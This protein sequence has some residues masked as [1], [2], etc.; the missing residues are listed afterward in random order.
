MKLSD[1][2]HLKQQ[3]I[4][5]ILQDFSLGKLK[6]SPF[7]V[8]IWSFKRYEMEYQ[9]EYYYELEAEQFTFYRIPKIIF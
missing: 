4:N 2:W 8:A 3:N 9:F 5:E 7:F 1:V 6:D